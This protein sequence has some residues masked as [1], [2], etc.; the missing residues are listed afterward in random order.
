MAIEEIRKRAQL[1]LVRVT[2]HA[3][4]EMQD[5]A[6]TTRNLLY[7]LASLRSSVIEDYPED[8]RGH[9]HLV[10]GWDELENPVHICCALCDNVVVIITTYRPDAR[11]WENDWKHR[12]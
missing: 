8:K 3:R 5:D 2:A 12:K 6:I 11:L 7:V 9:S 1:G 4:V 10:L